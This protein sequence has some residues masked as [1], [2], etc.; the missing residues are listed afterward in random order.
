MRPVSELKAIARR[1]ISKSFGCLSGAFLLTMLM[2]LTLNVVVSVIIILSVDLSSIDS[3]D[4][5]I[6]AFYSDRLFLL[7]SGVSL[8]TNLLSRLIFTGF[9]YITLQAARDRQP[10]LEGLFVPFKSNPDKVIIIAFLIYL[11]MIL[12]QFF[13]GI[14]SYLSSGTYGETGLSGR[15]INGG[16]YFAGMII[17]VLVIIIYI[18]VNAY[19][20]A[21]YYIYLDEP[22][23][24]V[25][26]IIRE[27]IALMKGNIWRYIYL[28]LTFAGWIILVAFTY[29]IAAIYVVPYMYTAYGLFYRDLKG[30]AGN[31]YY[32]EA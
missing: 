18:A 11:P 5:L 29:G 15:E 7:N 1:K 22:D 27:S 2:I 31:G 17:R 6:D 4:A 3:M 23:K 30:E 25:M 14:G 20:F 12:M 28:T 26:E 21:S 10:S 8:I 24:G 32:S 19:L 9:V 13:S 16:A